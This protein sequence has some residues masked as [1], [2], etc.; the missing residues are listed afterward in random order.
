MILLGQFLQAC[1]M[2]LMVYCPET[3]VDK[4]RELTLMVY[5]ELTRDFDELCTFASCPVDSQFSQEVAPGIT[6]ST[7]PVIHSVPTLA[8]RLDW[9]GKSITYSGDTEP[10]ADLIELAKNSDVLIHDS[11]YSAA[12][13]PQGNWINHS[14]AK[15]AAQTAQ[16]ANVKQLLLVHLIKEYAD[17]E[18]ILLLEASSEF[19]GQI[20]IP[21]DL[22]TIEI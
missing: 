6:L 3:A 7:L 5:P 10:S 12:L 19:S 13:D 11:N 18:G 15:A 8:M 1:S 21:D 4:L 9:R 2:P 17:Q 20:S 16:G 22:S 14:T